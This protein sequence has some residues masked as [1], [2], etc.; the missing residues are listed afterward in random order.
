VNKITSFFITFTFTVVFQS[1]ALAEAVMR[2]DGPPPQ[3][4]P[5]SITRSDPALDSIIDRNAKLVKLADGFGLNESPLW[6][7]EGN[8]GY[9]LV[10]GLLDNVIYKITPAGKVSVFL[11]YAGYSGDDVDNV[12]T[13]TRS[14]RSHVIL[15][16]PSCVGMDA[17]GRIVWC[18]S[19]DRAMMRLEK[20]GTRTVLATGHDGKRFGG[21]NDLTFKSDGAMY[22][23]DNDFGLRG[24]GNNPD[25]QMANGVWLIKDG[26]TKLVLKRAFLGGIPN[27]ITLSP[28]DKYLYLSAGSVMKRYEV[29][30]DDT[31]GNGIVFSEGPGIG[32]GMKV[33]TRGDIFSSGGAGRGYVRIVSPEGKLLGM[34]NMPVYGSEPKKQICVTNIA[35]GEKDNKT[36]FISACDAVYKVRLKVPGIAE[37]PQ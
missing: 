28:D 23:T 15:V 25:K 19:E 26:N 32:D 6:V 1:G 31:L 36:L 11:D 14:G 24:A 2:G 17:Q 29:K 8:S 13:Q 20:D 27:G 5:F 18:A 7:R 9:L 37:G 4:A 22:I 3:S 35:F 33:D 34:L 10:T 16:G 21:P 12:G 30:D